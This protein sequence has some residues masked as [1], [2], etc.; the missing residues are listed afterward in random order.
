MMIESYCLDPRVGRNATSLLALVTGFYSYICPTQ[1]QIGKGNKVK[2]NRFLKT[3]SF[4]ERS[5]SP[6]VRGRG[7]QP[8][9]FLFFKEWV[10]T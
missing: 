2:Y 4:F 10:L 6:E 8:F 1:T 3:Y 5:R 7:I 9:C